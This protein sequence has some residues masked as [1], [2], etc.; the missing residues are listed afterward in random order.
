MVKE[1]VSAAPSVSFVWEDYKG[2]L[3]VI[4]PEGVERLTTSFSNG[5]E[6]DAVRA[7]IHVV[8]SKD[9]SKSETTED[10]LIFPTAIVN[11]TKRQVGKVVVGRLTQGEN[12][13][14]KPPWLLAEASEQDMKAATAFLAQYVASTPSSADDEDEEGFDDEPEDDDSF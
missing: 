1:I 12:K 4:E 9:G 5:K 7:V 10:V 2:K 13:K 6:V 8:L 3:L 14:G 11:Q